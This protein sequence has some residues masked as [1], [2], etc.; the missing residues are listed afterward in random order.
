MKLEQTI[1]W[2]EKG[3]G[4]HVIV[5]SSGDAAIVAE[6]ELLFHKV[7]AISNLFNSLTNPGLMGHRELLLFTM[8]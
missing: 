2:S 4:G 3:P 5:G 8:S 7:T 1:N 6:Y